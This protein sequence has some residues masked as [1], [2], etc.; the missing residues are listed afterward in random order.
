MEKDTDIEYT[1]SSQIRERLRFET[2]L[3]DLSTRFV[4]LPVCRIDAEIEQGLKIITETLSI[5][6]CSVAQISSDR[7]SSSVS[8]SP[9]SAR[10]CFRVKVL[11][12]HIL[13]N[14]L[15]RLPLKSWISR[16]PRL[17][18]KWRD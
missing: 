17:K 12:F 9:D 18:P 11:W 4:N 10:N 5:D 7:T 2:M 14:C 6:R 13:K 8:S 15:S 1:S 3:A 16:Q